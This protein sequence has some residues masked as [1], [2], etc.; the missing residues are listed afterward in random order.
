MWV[1]TLTFVQIEN[2]ICFEEAT[3]TV[4]HCKENYFN[5]VLKFPLKIIKQCLYFKHVVKSHTPCYS[6]SHLFDKKN[7]F[8]EGMIL[9]TCLYKR[10][11]YWPFSNQYPF[12]KYIYH[13]LESIDNVYW[14]YN[15]YLKFNWSRFN[16][17]FMKEMHLIIKVAS[18]VL[19]AFKI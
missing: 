4:K 3:T 19:K 2:M 6:R 18:C 17:L 16:I 13:D 14:T 7:V 9:V 10:F 15:N 8:V 5:F 1:S 12:A 11:Y